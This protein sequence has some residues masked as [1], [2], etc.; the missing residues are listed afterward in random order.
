MAALTSWL[1][2]EA[3]QGS[4]SA[5]APL[6]ALRKL[7]HREESLVQR[8][9]A[10]HPEP[11]SQGLPWGKEGAR[12]ARAAP[13]CKLGS[14]TGEMCSVRHSSAWRCGVAQHGTDWCSMAPHSTA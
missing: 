13:S 6:P 12:N 14:G 7:W 4:A 1:C 5:A 2:Y 10:P 9:P 11:C 3:W 8:H